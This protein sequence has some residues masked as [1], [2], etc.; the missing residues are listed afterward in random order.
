MAAPLLDS[1]KPLPGARFCCVVGSPISHS[2]SPLIHRLFAEQ[3]GLRLQY[4]KFEVRPG[5][6]SGALATL[7]ALG[8]LGVNVTVPLKEEACR[9]GL[10][11]TPRASAAQAANTLWWGADNGLVVDNTDGA[12]LLNDLRHLPSLKISG[13]RILVLGAGGAAA[14][15]IPALLDAQPASLVI[16]NR[17]ETRAA[18]LIARFGDPRLR[19]LSL[20]TSSF[21]QPFELV[22]NATSASINDEV[23]KIGGEAVGPDTVCYDMFYSRADDTAFLRWARAQGVKFCRDG[24]GMLIEQAAIGF[25]QWHGAQPD[26]G[27]VF[28]A[29][30]R[31]LPGSMTRL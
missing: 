22:I 29:L 28:A 17:T 6:L 14:G 12:G 13:A 9:L 20:T 8:C 3:F 2:K 10:S 19:S 7:R 4:E 5:Q 27:P 11:L 18:A 21:R 1:F 31:P 26:T 15:V 30:D 24:L 16:A 23:P 25:A